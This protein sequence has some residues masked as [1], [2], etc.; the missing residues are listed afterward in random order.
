[1]HSN[2]TTF[3]ELQLSVYGLFEDGVERDLTDLGPA[4]TT[5]DPAVVSVTSSGELRFLQRGFASVRVEVEGHEA[6][7][8]IAVRTSPIHLVVEDVTSD[9][10]QLF[11]GNL[12]SPETV[13][14]FATTSFGP[15]SSEIPECERL[16]LELDAPTLLATSGP[17][18]EGQSHLYVTVPFPAGSPDWRIQ[19]V[20]GDCALSSVAILARP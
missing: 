3:P 7:V 4:F 18:P 9:S 20:T 13:R 15:G 8:P 14:V 10:A 1:V 12:V 16:D 11:L 2:P 5:S 19:A 6:T 17:V